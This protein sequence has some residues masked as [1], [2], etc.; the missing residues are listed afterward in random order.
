[1]LGFSAAGWVYMALR[2][3]VPQ[4]AVMM[5]LFFGGNYALIS[6]L[7]FFHCRCGEQR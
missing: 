4:Q 3:V 5:T 2:S 7:V 6:A 1:M